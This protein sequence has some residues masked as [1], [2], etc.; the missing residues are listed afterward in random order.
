MSAVGYR[1]K[2]GRGNFTYLQQLVQHHPLDYLGPHDEEG[3][4]MGNTDWGQDGITTTERSISN[5]LALSTEFLIEDMTMIFV[6]QDSDLTPLGTA[7]STIIINFILVWN[8]ISLTLHMD[9]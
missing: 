8:S 9:C 7:R 4:E 3:D 5:H 6:Q 2:Y 1:R